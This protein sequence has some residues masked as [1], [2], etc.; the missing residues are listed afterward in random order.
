MLT[1][2]LDQG[3]HLSDKQN[4][5]TVKD[6]KGVL[7]AYFILKYIAEQKLQS[8]HRA[9]QRPI[10]VCYAELN[11]SVRYKRHRQKACPVIAGGRAYKNRI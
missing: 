3:F 8:M 10:L 7:L 4:R 2:L 11:H 6:G 5:N 1:E 9:H